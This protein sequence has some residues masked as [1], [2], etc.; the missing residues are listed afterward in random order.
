M[1]YTGQGVLKIT[2]LHSL[3]KEASVTETLIQAPCLMTPVYQ[4]TDMVHAALGY[5][6]LEPGSRLIR[7][8]HPILPSNRTLRFAL[9]YRSTWTSKLRHQ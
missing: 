3:T 1:T 2:E 9:A 5:V 6:V 4:Y 8:P 7:F